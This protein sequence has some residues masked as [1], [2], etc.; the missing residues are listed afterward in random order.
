MKTVFDQATK[1]DIDELIRLRIAFVLD[2]YG[3]LSAHEQECMEKH[4]ADYFERKLGSELV[5]FVARVDG[6]IV[7]VAYLLLVEMPA[8]RVLLNGR[9]G[10]VLNVFTEK[11][12]RRKGLCTKLLQQLLEYGKSKE[13]GRIDLS[14]TKEGYPIYKSV[15]FEEKEHRYTDLRYVY[16]LTPLS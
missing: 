7:S 13:L 10:E 14:A 5:A 8:N 16:P 2:D 11:E 12:Y 15:G 4:L 9:Y 1:K 3:T 6:K